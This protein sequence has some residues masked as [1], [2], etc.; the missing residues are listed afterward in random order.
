VSNDSYFH[1]AKEMSLQDEYSGMG[2]Y[3][4]IMLSKNSNKA[5]II[6]QTGGEKVDE[7]RALLDYYDYISDYTYK[8]NWQNIDTG[9]V[10]V[11]SISKQTASKKKEVN[12]NIWYLSYHMVKHEPRF[13]NA[14]DC[15]PVS[16]VILFDIFNILVHDSNIPVK[17]IKKRHEEYQSVQCP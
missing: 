13:T 15:G 5:T 2:H 6:E 9:P 12:K 17:T 8:Y 16:L 7:K 10:I 3:I 4:F 11:Q 1:S 14:V